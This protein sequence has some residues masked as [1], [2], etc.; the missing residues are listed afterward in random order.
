MF[1]V[2]R[3]INLLN[4]S[5]DSINSSYTNLQTIRWRKP[6]WIPIART[7]RFRVPARTTIP[8]DE[9]LEIKRIY[10]NYH[11]A[12]KSLRRYLSNKYS[13]YFQSSLDP[14]EILKVFKQ[15]FVRCS[16]I[17]DKW[18]AEQKILREKRVAEQL[19]EELNYARNRIELELIK[20]EEKL[21]IIE[22]IVRKEKIASS[23]FITPENIDLAIEQAI[24]NE[25]DYN[26][27][28]DTNGEKIIGRENRPITEESK[29][30][31]KQ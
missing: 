6:R 12:V 17:N 21:E 22:D 24:T 28:I 13:T 10:N 14:E 11:T 26:F 5:T 15:D 8:E 9:A 2:A 29:I 4:I 7:K 1:H 31:I 20:E 23:D 18:N 16:A 30:A 19:E 27:A 3:K 25:V